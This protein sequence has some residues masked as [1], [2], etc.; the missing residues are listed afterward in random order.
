MTKLNDSIQA[1]AFNEENI[2][3]RVLKPR[4][5]SLWLTASVAAALVVAIVALALSSGILAPARQAYAMVSL[6]INPSLEIYTD[7]DGQV[8][9]VKA[10]N[11]DAESLSLAGLVGKP[12]DKVVAILIERATEAGFITDG[13]DVDDYV[14]VSTAILSDDPDAELK[15]DNLGRMISEGLLNDLDPES[16]VRVAV[17]KATK[18]ELF[19]ARDKKI[20]LGLYIIN[21]MVEK[22]SESIP[23]SEFVADA[24]NLRKLEHRAQMVEKKANKENNGNNGNNGNGNGNGNKG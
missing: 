10:I 6:D 5:R 24:N 2:L 1:H 13:D 23:V 3:T 7:E 9:E 14:I 11:E 20:P 18:R 16:D 17:I 15:Q 22:D 12:V 19:A 8:V 4:R 21:G